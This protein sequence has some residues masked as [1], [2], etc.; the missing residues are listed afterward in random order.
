MLKILLTK[1]VTEVTM[2]TSVQQHIQI[3]QD[4]PTDSLRHLPT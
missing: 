3:L 2:T 4:I 1:S